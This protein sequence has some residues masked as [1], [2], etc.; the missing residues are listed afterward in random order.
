MIIREKYLEKIRPFY[1]VDL[2][3][4]LTGIRR[5]GKSVILTQII[6]EIKNKGINLENII[7]INFELKE[8]SFIK[9]DDDLYKYIKEKM[10]N[11]KKYYIFL[12]EI[13]NIDRW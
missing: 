3:K 9:N 4:V 5:C 11:T 2:I 6:D 10:I 1:D 8:Y 13:Q 12:D 7:Y